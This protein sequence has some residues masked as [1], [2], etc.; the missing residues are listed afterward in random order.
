MNL[1][2]FK[3]QRY[4]ILCAVDSDYCQDEEIIEQLLKRI[5]EEQGR[6]DYA[7]FPLFTRNEEFVESLMIYKGKWI[8]KTIFTD[9]T[10]GHSSTQFDIL[11]YTEEFL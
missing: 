1:Y 7:T 11:V 3:S 4:S 10:H 8:R 2:G 6:N 5:E 9:M